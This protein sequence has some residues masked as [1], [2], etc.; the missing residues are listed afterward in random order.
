MNAWSAAKYLCLTIFLYLIYLHL[1]FGGPFIPAKLCV[2]IEVI[3]DLAGDIVN[4]QLWNYKK[5]NQTLQRSHHHQCYLH[6]HF[7]VYPYQPMSLDVARRK[8]TGTLTNL[9][10]S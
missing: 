2:L 4:N 8:H 3:M 5:N 10:Q 6:L 1:T 7:L 9:H